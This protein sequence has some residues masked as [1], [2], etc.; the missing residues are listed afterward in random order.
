M[1]RKIVFGDCLAAFRAG[2]HPQSRCRVC[3][4]LLTV[5]VVMV[6]FFLRLFITTLASS[7][8]IDTVK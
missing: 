6:E 8:E 2:N 4:G 1:D 3:H 7:T 5:G